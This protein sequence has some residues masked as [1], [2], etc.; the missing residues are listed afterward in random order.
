MT[1]VVHEQI[2]GILQKI[3]V[4]G[5]IELTAPPNAEMGDVAFPCFGI[6]KEMKK[7]PTEVAKEIA[8]KL[9]PTLVGTST[10]AAKIIERVQAFGPYVNFFFN[11]K[12]AARLILEDIQKQG[13]M[14]GSHTI[15]TG[16]KY[17]IE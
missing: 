16:K 1:F 15:G 17:L 14:Y 6:A 4:E 2:Q 9:L 7:N 10:T 8:D 11:V 5:K 3:G 12:E 13:K